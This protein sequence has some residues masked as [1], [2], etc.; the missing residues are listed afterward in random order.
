MTV[1]EFKYPLYFML[2][3][4]NEEECSMIFNGY[5]NLDDENY[6]YSLGHHIWNKYIADIES[7]G[8]YDAVIIFLMNDLDKECLQKLIDYAL[9]FYRKN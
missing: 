9:N 1:E 3:W 7:Y 6:L 5:R 8:T 4:W 2:N